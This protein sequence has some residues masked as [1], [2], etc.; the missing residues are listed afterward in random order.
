MSSSHSFSA[1][2]MSQRLTKVRAQLHT[3]GL[4]ALFTQNQANIRY[5]TGF[6]GEPHT[7]F[8]TQDE[9]IL[10][11]SFRTLPW[12]QEQTQI[13]GSTLQLS[14][15]PALEETAKRLAGGSQSPLTLG[16]DRTLSHL[17]F[18]SLEKTL[19]NHHL[20]P[21]SPIEQVRRCKSPAEIELLTHSQRL[22][23]AIF[24]AVIPQIQLGMTER[25]V[26]GLFLTEM[27]RR[28]EVDR[29]S[30]APIVATGRNA[31]EIH[32]LPD[33]TVI[34]NNN[35]LLLDL[36]VIYQ[37]YASDMT[38]TIALGHPTEH[39]REVYATITQAQE[40]AIASMR[41]GA[42]THA[43]DAAAREVITQAGHGKG[44]THGLGHSIGLETHDP[45]LN[46]S[47]FTNDE[48][49]VPGMAFTVEP[50]TYFKDGFGVRTEDVLIVTKDS[51][52]NITQ[53]P[54]DLLEL[55]L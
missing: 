36:G 39:M 41:P 53:Q 37:G 18:L 35:L 17:A 49:L 34:Q 8:L 50:G 54:K 9:A 23:E 13:L 26:Q 30:F 24:E 40:A 44:F 32:H 5:L 38:R 20:V 12:A 7:L 3:S 51:P 29:A 31:W 19:L 45:G 25:A 16:V 2:E 6:R 48:T 55:P 33:N 27:A 43:V 47:P 28:E 10:Y 21:A 42:S 14:T 52:L 1:H 46:L 22:N 11:T 4:D 15:A